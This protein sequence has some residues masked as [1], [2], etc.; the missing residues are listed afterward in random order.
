LGRAPS[1]IPALAADGEREL[2]AHLI[3]ALGLQPTDPHTAL[4]D[5][6]L[7]AAVAE[8][9]QA[10]LAEPATPPTRETPAGFR[11]AS[12]AAPATPPSPGSMAGLLGTSAVMSL[13]GQGLSA[14]G[15]GVVT[16]GG[17]D[18]T[19]DFRASTKSRAAARRTYSSTK[20]RDGV[21]VTVSAVSE[22]DL[23]F[24]PDA[25]D[26]IAGELEF[27]V[28][29]DLGNP[30]AQ[31]SGSDHLLTVFSVQVDDGA[32]ATLVD[33]DVT[34]STSATTGVGSTAPSGSF[35][36]VHLAG[37]HDLTT[38]SGSVSDANVTRSSRTVQRAATASC[39][40]GS[41]SPHRP[42]SRTP[43]RP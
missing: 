11:S 37:S 33:L 7:L 39:R 4:V 28:R 30:P 35:V 21:A 19:G 20:V 36:E 16:D 17:F 15:N 43:P 12:P 26:Q 13:V 40:T 27:D 29:I 22:F 8:I 25:A 24:C 31:R 32:N 42:T 2:Q 6:A 14:V 38:D 10:T 41:P 3:D 5:E 18:Q 9:P 23:E 1:D 34:G